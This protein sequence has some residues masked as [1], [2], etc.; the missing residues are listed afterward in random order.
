MSFSDISK[1]CRQHK[2]PLFADGARLAYA[3]GSKEND[4]SL[5]DLARLTDVFYIGGTKCGT[6]FGEAVV[7][8]KPELIPH[9]LTQIKQHGALL[10]KGRLLGIQFAELFKNDLY[11]ELGKTADSYAQKI[12]DA[13]TAAGYK[14]YFVS[15][16]NQVFFVIENSKLQPLEQKVMYGFMEKYD[17]NHTVIRF[18]TSWATTENDVEKLLQVIKEM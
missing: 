14:L 12:Q 7:V 3:L 2:I 15:P 11:L 9:F 4:V 1:V 18:C 6:L 8:P 17:E 16:T 10:A 13:L 5:K